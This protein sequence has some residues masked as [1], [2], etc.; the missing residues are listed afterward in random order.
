MAESCNVFSFYLK[1]ELIN[2]TES[3]LQ[4]LLLVFLG[5]VV[6]IVMDMRVFGH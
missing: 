5:Q 1:N 2:L 6:V 3:I 4:P